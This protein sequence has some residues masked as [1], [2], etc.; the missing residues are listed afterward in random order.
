[1]NEQRGVALVLVLAVTGVLALLILQIGL[2]SRQQVAQAQALVDRAE[3]T[4]RLHSRESAL[5]YSMLTRERNA[6]PQL[7]AGDNPY[8]AKWNFRGDRFDVDGASIRLQDLGGLFPIP[9]PESPPREFAALLIGLGVDPARA[10]TTSRSLQEAISTPRRSPLQSI[11]ELAVVGELSVEEIERVRDVATLYPVATL[12]PATAPEAVLAV[13]YTGLA[14]E[15]LVAA[16]RESSLDEGR[17]RAII[18]E[19]WDDMMTTF[20]VGPGFRLDIAVEFRGVRLRRESV[21]TVRPSNEA[22]PLDL[23]SYRNLDYRSGEAFGVAR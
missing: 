20:L 13:K 17:V 7:I 4:L 18:G 12:N 8:A 11:T 16:R 21:W 22:A 19:N 9:L 1:M 15:G 6:D 23:W 2:T 3:A 10:E 14:L 5:L